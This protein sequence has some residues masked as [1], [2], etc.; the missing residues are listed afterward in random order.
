MHI[1]TVRK[2]LI[3]V[4]AYSYFNTSTGLRLAAFQLCQQTVI[5]VINRAN[6]PARANIHQLNPVL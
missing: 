4:T 1:I 2:A 3:P 5:K 6:N